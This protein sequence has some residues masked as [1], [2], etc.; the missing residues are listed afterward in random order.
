MA[1]L[2]PMRILVTGGA[3]YIGSHTV[4]ALLDQGN[5]VV[6]VDLKSAPG[7]GVL[8]AA[9]FVGADIADTRLIARLL[10]E[11]QVDG[12]IHFAAHKSVA[13]S[14]R[15]PGSYFRN[16]VAGS[17]SVLEAMV[18][19]GTRHIVFSSSCAVYGTPDKCPVD[20]DAPRRP[21]SPY[22]ASKA[23]VEDMLRWFGDLDRIR[24]V[25]LRYFNAAGAAL[26]ARLGEDG[27][28]STMLIPA[29][30]T[31]VAGRREPVDIY[32]TDYPTPDGTAIRDYIH[33]LDLADA[34]MRALRY[35]EAGG[36]SES[37][38]LGTGS[39]QSVREVINIAATVTGREVPVR[40]CGRR[41]GDPAA[42]WAQPRR[43]HEVLGWRAQYDLTDIVRSAWQWHSSER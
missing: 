41:A 24:Y 27:R 25:S 26:D 1:K 29:L 40:Y 28:R 23:M 10:T 30:M 35:L 16:N 21:E 5:H 38:N 31:A 32:G 17:L 37:L 11:H 39:G 19:A 34:H 33:V 6:V 42:V 13:E 36:Y 9:T 3:G 8:S 15:S 2:R 20:E 4:R 43:A 18:Q 14:M 22:G 12:V 7:N